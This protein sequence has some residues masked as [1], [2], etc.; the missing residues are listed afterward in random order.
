MID[1]QRY[2]VKP[3]RACRN[4]RHYWRTGGEGTHPKDAV[5]ATLFDKLNLDFIRDIA[6]VGGLNRIVGVLEVHPSFSNKTVPE[7]I[8]YGKANPAKI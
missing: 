3:R 1:F 4:D 8:A 6:T 5:N 2:F 7:L